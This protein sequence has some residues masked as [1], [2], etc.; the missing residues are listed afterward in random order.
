MRNVVQR[1]CALRRTNFPRIKEAPAPGRAS[2]YSERKKPD[3]AHAHDTVGL[4]PALSFRRFQWQMSHYNQWQMSHQQSCVSHKMRIAARLHSGWTPHRPKPRGSPGR[5]L[6]GASA[7][8]YNPLLLT[9]SPTEFRKQPGFCQLGAGG[10]QPGQ[11][12]RCRSREQ[13]IFLS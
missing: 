2:S 1:L 5:H 6:P 12:E 11:E 10:C 7:R 4:L 13:F 8:S 3:T 9:R